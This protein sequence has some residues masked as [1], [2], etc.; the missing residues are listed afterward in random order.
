MRSV[1]R[2]EKN[3]P[4]YVLI[5]LF[6][7]ILSGFSGLFGMDNYLYP[8][9]EQREVL[10]VFIDYGQHGETERYMRTEIP[11][12]DHVRDPYVA[13][14]HVLITSSR[15]GSDGRRFNI[16]FIGKGRFAGQDQNLFH[17]SPQ[18]D[19][20]DKRRE[21]LT[22]IIKMG[23][24]PYVSQTVFA[25]QVEIN[26]D[27]DDKGKKV[28]PTYDPW[29]YWIFNID[30]AGGG[31][32]EES[33][34]AFNVSTTVRADRI[35]DNWKTRNGFYYRY[36][37]EN[38][39]DEGESLKSFLKN[40]F[41]W[42]S[43]VKSLS[44]KWS[45]GLS[46][47]VQSTTFRNIRLG[48]RISPAIEYNFFP[49]NEA[50]RRKLVL[51]YHLGVETLEYYEI[52]I[53]DKFRQT[54]LFH[55]LDLE[56]EMTQPWGQLDFDFEAR[57]YPMLKNTYSLK[58]DMDFAVRFSSAFSFFVST[59]LEEIHDQIYLSKGELSIDEILLRR[60]QLATTFDIRYRLG[61]RFTFG[62]IYNN[63]VNHRL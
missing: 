50:E 31:R 30:L 60:K 61:I 9:E 52:T 57:Q 14:V 27:Y 5:L 45:T 47:Q 44:D 17:I 12:V 36:E 21:G 54:L 46:G 56:L 38:F 41:A 48:A 1:V 63:V 35:T 7:L 16:S 58:L 51:A 39:S 2:I 3:Y 43:L 20:N 49:W 23:L 55:S 8:V 59:R 32:A 25:D 22:Q 53:Y 37:E 62:S 11:F 40:W 6:L 42:S 29:D 28:T 4:F 10:K 13:Q 19:T 18:S 33:T 24:M 15:T 34:N 26:Y